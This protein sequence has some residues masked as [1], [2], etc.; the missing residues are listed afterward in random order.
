[1][2]ERRKNP[3]S[4]GNAEKSRNGVPRVVW[5]VLSGLLALGLIWGIALMAKKTTTDTPPI[6]APSPSASYTATQTIRTVSGKL[7]EQDKKDAVAAAARI[8]KVAGSSTVPMDKRLEALDNGDESSVAPALTTM[9]AWGDNPSKDF[10]RVTLQSLIAMEAVVKEKNPSKKVHPAAED[11]WRA[12]YTDSKRGTVY[13]PIGI[14]TGTSA[15]F[16]MEMVYDKDR[17]WMLAPYGFVDAVRASTMV[18][19]SG[20]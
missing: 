7:P 4:V 16:T 9:I 13:V 6:P 18:Q 1:M 10:R 12:A 5:I 2:A 15:G 11:A 19:T 3:R 17:G 8:L 14:F 20:K